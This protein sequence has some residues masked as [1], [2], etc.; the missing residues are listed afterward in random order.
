MVVDVFDGS[1]SEVAVTFTLPR[2]AAPAACWA[3]TWTVVLFPAFAVARAF[4]SQADQPLPVEVADR[5]YTSESLYGAVPAVPVLRS[6]SVHGPSRL[7]RRDA[8]AGRRPYAALLRAGAV[9]RPDRDRVR[10]DAGLSRFMS[11]T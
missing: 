10:Q 7:G 1:L 6:G 3:Y 2:W 11:S 8:E 5:R 9:E 4:G